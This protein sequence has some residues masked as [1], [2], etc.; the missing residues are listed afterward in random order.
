MENIVEL[1]NVSK[2]YGEITAL[3]D[4]SLEI[5]RGEIFS[6]MGI[7]GAGK[8]TLLRIIAGIDKPTSGEFYYNKRLVENDYR[9]EVRRNCTMVFQKCVLFK[10]SVYKNVAYGLKFRGY[11]GKEIEIKVR[12]VLKKLRLSGYE[13]RQ[14]RSLSGGEQQRVSLARALV[15]EPEL[16]LLDE[17]TLNLDP[18]NT[19]IVENVIKDLRGETTIV[20]ATNDLYLA[21]NISDTIAHILDGTIIETGTPEE[22]FKNPKDERTRRF[23][24]KEIVF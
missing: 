19:A 11:S 14:A 12:E 7:N 17:P 5:R 20:L 10:T 9:K 21:R 23:I 13:N 15:L 2:K 24:K 3:R 18:S 4:I 16:L 8:T 6:I 22:I 1:K